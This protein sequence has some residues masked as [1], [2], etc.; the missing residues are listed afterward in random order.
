MIKRNLND[1]FNE[2]HKSNPYVFDL[3]IRFTME[4]KRRGYKR[5]SAKAVFER[6]RWHMNV[7]TEDADGFKINNNY[8]SRYVRL[9]E[10]FFP[11]HK[12]F[13]RK[14]ELRS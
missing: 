3:F 10:K 14:R 9:L 7:E 6:I 4:A 13:Y 8:T 2:Y 11:E 1:R 5:F 12:D